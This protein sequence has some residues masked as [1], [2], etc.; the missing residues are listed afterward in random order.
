[1]PAREDHAQKDT[2]ESPLTI[3][4]ELV[5]FQQV[6]LYAKVTGFVAGN[7]S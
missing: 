7:E 1:M 6:D 4:G 2:L 5:A 3:P